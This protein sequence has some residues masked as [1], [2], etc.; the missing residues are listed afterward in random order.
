MPE[1]QAYPLS[2]RELQLVELLSR[3]LTNREIAQELTISPNT[4]KAHLRIIYGKLAC[5]ANKFCTSV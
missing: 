1:E 5:R 2:E 4:V 3:G